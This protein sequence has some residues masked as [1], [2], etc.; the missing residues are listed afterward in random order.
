MRRNITGQEK[1]EGRAWRTYAGVALSHEI[2]RLLEVSWKPV[3]E[4]EG[5]SWLIGCYL[6]AWLG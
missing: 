3:H 4:S 6:A 1:K 5:G 2:G